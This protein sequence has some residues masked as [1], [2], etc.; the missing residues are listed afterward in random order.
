M[1]FIESVRTCLK[2]NYCNFE[3]LHHVQSTG[4]LHYLRH[5]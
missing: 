4:G 1:T 3:G 2:E 5:F